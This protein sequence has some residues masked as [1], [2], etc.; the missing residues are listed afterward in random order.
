MAGP[1]V[2]SSL[3]GLTAHPRFSL[4]EAPRGAMGR[5][6]AG[7]ALEHQRIFGGH[8]VA[9]GAILQPLE[10]AESYAEHLGHGPL[11]TMAFALF[12]EFGWRHAAQAILRRSSNCGFSQAIRLPML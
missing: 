2:R 12:G 3:F 7:E 4:P 9:R 5:R 1:V 11:R 10:R 8:R 6:L